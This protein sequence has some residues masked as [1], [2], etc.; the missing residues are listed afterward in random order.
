MEELWKVCTFILVTMKEN[1]WAVIRDCRA[2][3]LRG[4]HVVDLRNDVALG[5]QLRLMTFLLFVGI[6]MFLYGLLL[7]PLEIL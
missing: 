3:I 4:G 5:S 2:I 7:E 1:K 6:V